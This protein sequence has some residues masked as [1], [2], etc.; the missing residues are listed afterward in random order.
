MPTAPK[1]HGHTANGIKAARQQ[2]DRQRGAAHQRGYTKRWSDYSTQ[3]C[4][5]RVFCELCATLGI[6]TPIVRAPEGQANGEII[7]IVDHIVP[8]ENGQHDT[9]FWEPSN[10]WCLCVE[11]DRWKSITFD[12]GYGKPKRQAVR[13]LAG[14]QARRVEVVRERQARGVV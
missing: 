5:E 10:H 8:V 11:C 3:L 7:S 4:R 9:L 13:T 12:G 1:R 14:V 6:D 2:Y